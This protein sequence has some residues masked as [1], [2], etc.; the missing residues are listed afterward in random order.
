MLSLTDCLDFI[1]LDRATVEIIAEHEHLP[2]VVA[3]ELG[4]KLLATQKGIYRIH[5][6]HRNLIAIAAEKGS[7][8]REKELRQLYA[9]FTRKYPMPRHL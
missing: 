2:T 6:M 8:A 3:T 9:A 5:E 7:L 4:D 1:D